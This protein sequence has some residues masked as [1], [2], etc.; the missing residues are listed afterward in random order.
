MVVSKDT[1]DVRSS[2]EPTIGHEHKAHDISIISYVCL[3]CIDQSMRFVIDQLV[4]ELRSDRE[5]D[6]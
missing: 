1:C 6:I 4:G 2:T 3:I 5:S